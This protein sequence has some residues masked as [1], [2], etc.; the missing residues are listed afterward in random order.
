MKI[1]IVGDDVKTAPYLK[2]G[3]EENG[4]IA[5]LATMERLVHFSHRVDRMI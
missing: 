1:L 2:L 3:L 5:D 4:L